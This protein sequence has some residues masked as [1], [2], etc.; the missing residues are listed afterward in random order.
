MQIPWWIIFIIGGIILQNNPG[1]FAG[2]ATVGA[3]CFW[4]GIFLVVLWLILLAALIDAALSDN[5]RTSYR[6]P[7][8]R[9]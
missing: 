2:A 8:R 5:R 1:W 4:F 7:R 6:A 9:F 3:I